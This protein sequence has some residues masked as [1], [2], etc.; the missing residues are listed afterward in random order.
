MLFALKDFLKKSHPLSNNEMAHQLIL[1]LLDKLVPQ[2]PVKLEGYLIVHMDLQSDGLCPFATRRSVKKAHEGPPQAQASEFRRDRYPKRRDWESF[3]PPS[4]QSVSEGFVSFREHI[5]KIFP[6]VIAYPDRI[7]TAE[8][9]R[10][11]PF[12]ISCRSKGGKQSLQPLSQTGSQ[13]FYLERS[14]SHI[15]SALLVFSSI[16]EKT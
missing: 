9:V 8:G 15:K 3:V 13:M 14:F 10:V 12:F 4:Q 1:V 5:I 16:I 7:L 11:K 2:R 6:P